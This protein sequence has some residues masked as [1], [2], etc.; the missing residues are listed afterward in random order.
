MSHHEPQFL[1][2]VAQIQ[3]ALLNY[4]GLVAIIIGP[5][6]VFAI[7]V[8]FLERTIQYR[9]AERFGWG[10]VLWTGWLGTP[11][12]EL[13]H[14][15]MCLVFRHRIDAISLFEPDLESG[16]LGYVKHSWR[17]GNWFEELGNLF[18]AIAPL[19][20]GSMVLL[21]LLRLFYPA[22][23]LL[24]SPD[25]LSTSSLA[26]TFLINTFQV[27]FRLESIFDIKF[28]IF[29]YLV[30]CVGSH[31]A[32]SRSDYQGAT[33]GA[34]LFV[35][36]IVLVVFLMAVTI[37]DSSKIH[38]GA[39]QILMPLFAALMVAMMLCAIATVIVLL[40]VSYF[41]SVSGPGSR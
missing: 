40:L 29:V 30:L 33:K 9:L 14:A 6:I 11:I 5:L 41:Q 10:S 3:I 26:P 12:H 2:I 15:A 39:V 7:V 22:V 34:V 18:I 25:P 28:W 37:P 8:H 36:G 32:P 38:T 24:P 17:K 31:M 20:G 19:I 27:L 21:I 4:F 1:F 13:S 16:R 35:I 23:F